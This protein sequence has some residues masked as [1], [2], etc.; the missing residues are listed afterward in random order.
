MS[1]STRSP[2]NSGCCASS[3]PC[4]PAADDS[5]PAT[6]GS[7]C[8]ASYWADTEPAKLSS[9]P[10]NL[11]PGWL[12]MT[13]RIGTQPARLRRLTSSR[14]AY[15]P[16]SARWAVPPRSTP[17]DGQLRSASDNPLTFDSTTW[18]PAHLCHI[19]DKD[20]QSTGVANGGDSI[21]SR[22][23]CSVAAEQHREVRPGCLCAAHLPAETGCQQQH[24]EPQ[25]PPCGRCRAPAAD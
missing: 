4:R 16:W 17:A 11:S 10:S 6:S 7:A 21:P 15:S 9:T 12:I 25:L 24:P 14:R 2:T 20:I 18:R 3:R 8:I 1:V 13:P 19:R 5:L 22:E 23:G